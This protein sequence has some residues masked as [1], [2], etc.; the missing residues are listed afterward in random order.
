MV[1]HFR[2]DL[3]VPVEGQTRCHD[4]SS[5]L[6]HSGPS[7]VAGD[8]IL[9]T[10]ACCPTRSELPI[11]P[12]TKVHKASHCALHFKAFRHH[13]RLYTRHAC[14]GELEPYGRVWR[15]HAQQHPLHSRSRE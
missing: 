1:L 13:L 8:A 12:E 9:H 14:C 5:A 3:A 4:H 11:A 10:A 2:P 7:T 15:V 6:S